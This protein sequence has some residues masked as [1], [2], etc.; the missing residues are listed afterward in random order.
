MFFKTLLIILQSLSIITTLFGLPGNIISLVFPLI[1]YLL[2]WITLKYFIII[3]ILIVLGEILEFFAGLFTTKADGLEK[4]TY[5]F[6]IIT[7]IILSIFMAPF[8]LGIGALIGAFLGAFLGAVIFEYF[9][10]ADMNKAIKR[11]IAVFKGRVLGTFIKLA[12]GF[13][14]VIIMGV[15]LF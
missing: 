3:T 12:I 1:A 4:G 8:L 5:T 15:N 7:G 10:H 9:K 13:S 14:T 11:G 6:S 2:H